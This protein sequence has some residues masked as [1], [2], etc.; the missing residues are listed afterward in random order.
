MCVDERVFS[1]ID[2]NSL[3][4]LLV[5][6]RERCVTRAAVCLQVKQPAVSNTLAKLRSQ[7]GDPLFI[8]HC[9]GVT[10]T[11]KAVEI[12]ERLGPAFGQI[13]SILSAAVP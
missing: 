13:E 1:D 3:L 2:L 4:T 6:Y 10:P 8:R 5:V 9:R 7:F 11:P 12:V